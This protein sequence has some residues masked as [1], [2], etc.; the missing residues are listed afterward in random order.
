MSDQVD[1]RDLKKAIGYYNRSA[2]NK[3]DEACL[4]LV[5]IQLKNPKEL[6]SEAIPEYELLREQGWLSRYEEGEWVSEI[7]RIEV[8]DFKRILNLYFEGN[9]GPA[10]QI[11]E[12]LCD[13]FGRCIFF[14]AI[15]KKIPVAAFKTF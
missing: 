5:G 2:K 10:I 8:R 12:K 14:Y 3:I 15:G 4:K 6:L 11:N 7:E 9:L 1:V 13:G